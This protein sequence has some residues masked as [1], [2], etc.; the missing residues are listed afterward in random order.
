MGFYAGFFLT[1]CGVLICSKNMEKK[2]IL[3]IVISLALVTSIFFSKDTCI[4]KEADLESVKLIK[5]DPFKGGLLSP[6]N[7]IQHY[8]LSVATVYNSLDI[9]KETIL[10]NFL[11]LG[12]DNYKIAI[13][14]ANDS[15]DFHRK[16]YD[17]SPYYYL[18]LNT[19]RKYNNEDGSLVFSKGVVE[20]GI[21]FLAF[22]IF[23]I[24]VA[25]STKIKNPEKY[26]LLSLLF[27][28]IFIRGSGY[29]YNGFLIC[30]LMIML[31]FLKFYDKKNIQK[32]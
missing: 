10:K 24:C 31:Y 4:S 20:F 25:F 12:I 14:I 18:M 16:D 2:I 32:P 29:F 15:S 17:N 9:A 8:N 3:L 28:Q 26:F 7:K 22:V 19:A 30:S 13:T 21:L 23:L 1:G 11:G 27:I 5:S 6:K